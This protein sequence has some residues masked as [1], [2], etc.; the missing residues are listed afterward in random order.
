MTTHTT[1]ANPLTR[2]ALFALLAILAVAPLT[3][4]AAPP[5]PRV[6]T[7]S[8]AS[9]PLVDFGPYDPLG[10]STLAATG[11][12]MISCTET[13]G[14]G[15]STSVTVTVSVTPSATTAR[16]MSAGGADVILYELYTDA[17][18]TTVWGDGTTN[19]AITVTLN[20][21]TSGT[22]NTT[23]NFYGLI[24]PAGQDVAAAASYL[25][26]L[27]VSYTYSCASGGAC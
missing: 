9:A 10:V 2:R 18:H 1:T 19:P 6:M 15:G 4:R 25:Q 14:K 17:A 21:P 16:Q 11:S 13:N 5:A 3:A 26:T 23:I 7:C 22:A 12:M 24:T 20:V 27:P 8:L